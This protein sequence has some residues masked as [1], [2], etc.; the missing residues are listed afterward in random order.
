MVN[1][2]IAELA[3]APVLLVADI[4][5]GGVFAS[6]VGTI[7]LLSPA[8]RQRV[9]G[10]LINKFRGDIRLLD[11]GLRLLEERAGIPVLGVLP[12]LRELRIPQEDSATLDTAATR[13]HEK[14]VTFGVV[15]VPRIANY[16]D[17]ALLE[18]EPDVAVHYVS[19]PKLA[20]CP[21]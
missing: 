2:T 7:A 16:T 8:E 11:S 18:L 20:F 6:L 17:F 14:P 15:R 10:F 1:W 5:K 13:S 12:Y 19:D 9:K 21:F 3:D 4:D